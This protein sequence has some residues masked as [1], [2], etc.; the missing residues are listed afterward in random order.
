[1]LAE[2]ATS[3]TRVKHH[4]HYASVS[5]AFRLIY[6][7]IIIT[8]PSSFCPLLIIIWLSTLYL[9]GRTVKKLCKIYH[10]CFH[11]CIVM[12]HNIVWLPATL[13]AFHRGSIILLYKCLRVLLQCEAVMLAGVMIVYLNYHTIAPQRIL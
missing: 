1:M 12:K 7:I 3:S 8:I 6:H 5:N 10:I 2:L 13:R 11:E 9:F 4:R